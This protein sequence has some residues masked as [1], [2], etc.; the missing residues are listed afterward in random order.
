MATQAH[1]FTV[2]TEAPPGVPPLQPH[3]LLVLVK[4]PEGALG[5]SPLEMEVESSLYR[6]TVPPKVQPG[7]P[8]YVRVPRAKETGPNSLA[9]SKTTAA[10]ASGREQ[11]SSRTSL[12]CNDTDDIRVGDITDTCQGDTTLADADAPA[13][14]ENGIGSYA[15]GAQ[16]VVVGLTKMPTG[17]GR[18]CQVLSYDEELDR[19]RVQFTD[20]E[21]GLGCLRFENLRLASDSTKVGDGFTTSQIT[22]ESSASPSLAPVDLPANA[23]NDTMTGAADASADTTPPEQRNASANGSASH[24]NDN[25]HCNTS[26]S[27]L[28]NHQKIKT[29][30]KTAAAAATAL[31]EAQHEVS[32]LRKE[33]ATC[34]DAIDNL[35]DQR[36]YGPSIVN[37]VAGTSEPSAMPADKEGVSAPGAL[38]QGYR[39]EE[40]EAL[41]SS[42]DLAA[43]EFDHKNCATS[44]SAR[45]SG[46][47]AAA[48]LGANELLGLL[49]VERREVERA[50]R[51]A[52][53]A[54]ARE[55]SLNAHVDDLMHLALCAGAANGNS[56]ASDSSSVGEEKYSDQPPSKFDGHV[57]NSADAENQR[58][59]NDNNDSNDVNRAGPSED[60][61]TNALFSTMSTTAEP[62]VTDTARALETRGSPPPWVAALRAAVAEQGDALEAQRSEVTALQVSEVYLYFLCVRITCSFLFLW[63]SRIALPVL[64]LRAMIR[65]HLG[66][67]KP[68]RGTLIFLLLRLKWQSWNGAVNSS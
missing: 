7:Q 39:E 33:L 4:C 66:K 21:G 65:A 62:S 54:T 55:E 44:H 25:P 30:G 52:S 50:K 8:F 31:A 15:P 27:N 14:T 58:I 56:N 67:N 9:A 23:A 63:L 10:S 6:I 2:I 37:E 22:E 64:I 41:F 11:P 68:P 32:L 19:F 53:V 35:R 47:G 46:L 16:V 18:P 45:R 17:N 40:E 29:K 36:L 12:P 42:N 3:E 1:E 5:G 13:A 28:A 48:A 51:L 59:S 20:D 49:E 34:Y 26:N 38:E 60:S 43:T 61:T 57:E 24:V